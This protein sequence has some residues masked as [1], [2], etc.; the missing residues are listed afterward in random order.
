MKIL[1]I[2]LLYLWRNYVE[3]AASCGKHDMG[4]LRSLLSPGGL[5]FLDVGLTWRNSKKPEG[6]LRG[7]EYG[8]LAIKKHE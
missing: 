2:S 7:G 1:F 4:S 3:N 6:I 5:E 8:E